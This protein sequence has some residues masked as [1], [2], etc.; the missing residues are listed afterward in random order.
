MRRLVVALALALV[1]M[2]G[3]VGCGSDAKPVDA[4]SFTC[5]TDNTKH[6]PKTRFVADMGLLAGTFHHWIWKPYKAGKFTKGAD[7]RTVALVKAG[8]ASLLMAKLTKNA[9]SNVEASPALCNSIGQPLVKLSNAVSGLGTKIR[10][11][12]LGSLTSVSGIVGTLTGSMAS[13]G[14]KV[15]ETHQ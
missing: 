12:D 10:H 3:L 4:A 6:F 13:S 15:T 14:M 7:G 8:G 11:G 5:P 1:A 2:L 9:I